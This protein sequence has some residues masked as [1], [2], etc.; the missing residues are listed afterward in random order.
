LEELSFVA[1]LLIAAAG[2]LFGGILLGIVCLV[3]AVYAGAVFWT[4]L[5][6]Y[7]WIP[8]RRESAILPLADRLKP[9]L[10]EGA[11]LV[12]RLDPA[13]PSF[14]VLQLARAWQDEVYTML[15]GERRDLAERFLDVA[16]LIEERE[17]QALST[18]NP[19][20][21]IVERHMICVK[22]II[23]ELEAEKGEMVDVY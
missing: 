1:M 3:V 11:A 4:P 2:F 14:D 21:L 17:T 23:E 10:S 7:L 5:R 19:A 9:S 22:E 13:T 6:G 12:R 8:G 20:R 16:D 15:A 18:V